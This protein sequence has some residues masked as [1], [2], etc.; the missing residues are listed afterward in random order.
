MSTVFK[1]GHLLMHKLM[2]ERCELLSF[3]GYSTLGCKVAAY[4]LEGGRDHLQAAIQKE[5]VVVL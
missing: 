2:Q 4:C 3:V 5:K 1:S